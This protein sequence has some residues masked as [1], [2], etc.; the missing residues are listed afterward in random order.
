MGSD[1]KVIQAA[2]D[3]EVVDLK[4]ALPIP[5]DCIVHEQ[6]GAFVYVKSG[7]G[8]HKQRVKLGPQN[9]LETVIESGLKVGEAVRRDMGQG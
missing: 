9:N 2:V 5:N 3:V 6:G 8:F 4:E 1:E 7:R